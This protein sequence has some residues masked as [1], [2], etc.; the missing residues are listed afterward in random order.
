MSQLI[1]SH[2]GSIQLLDEDLDL[3]NGATYPCKECKQSSILVILTPKDYVAVIQF[4]S[5]SEQDR[6]EQI[7]QLI[8]LKRCREIIQNSKEFHKKLLAI[9]S[10]QNPK[11]ESITKTVET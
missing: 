1:C 9:A 2:C 3:E 7:N 5:H 10:G 6:V 4:L 11:T 8:K